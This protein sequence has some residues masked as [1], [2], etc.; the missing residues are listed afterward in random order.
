M[1]VTF[2]S[3]IQQILSVGILCAIRYFRDTAANKNLSTVLLVAFS[4]HQGGTNSKYVINK[5]NETVI[6]L[7]IYGRCYI[8]WY[9]CKDKKKYKKLSKEEHFVQREQLA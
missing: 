4:F 9:L 5:K 6:A 2:D 1:S 7:K 3:L 8:K